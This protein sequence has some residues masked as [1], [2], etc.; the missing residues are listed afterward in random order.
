MGEK[1]RQLAATAIV[2]IPRGQTAPLTRQ[3][4]H[5]TTDEGPQQIGMSRIVATSKLPVLRSFVLH[6]FELLLG[7]N[8]RDRRNRDP[9]L[10]RSHSPGRSRRAGAARLLEAPGIDLAG[11]DRVGQ[12]AAQGLRSSAPEPAGAAPRPG[13]ASGPG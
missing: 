4:T 10:P 5:A 3:A 1:H 12:D 9:V 8:G 2:A 7:D 6:A 11:V 13:A